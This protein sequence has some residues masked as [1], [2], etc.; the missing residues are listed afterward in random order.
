MQRFQKNVIGTASSSGASIFAETKR[1]QSEREARVTG[2]ER[3][4][5]GTTGR[6]RKTFAFPS[7]LARPM[8][9]RERRLGTRQLSELV[10]QVNTVG[11]E[12]VAMGDSVNPFTPRVSYGPETLQ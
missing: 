3:E 6:R 8:S 12:K 7:S 4:A 10:M 11:M 5:R 9:E 1:E 2:D